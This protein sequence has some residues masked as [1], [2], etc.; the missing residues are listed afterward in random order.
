MNKN[1]TRKRPWDHVND[2][3]PDFQTSFGLLL[4]L[5]HLQVAIY[6]QFCVIAEH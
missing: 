3:Q 2:E 6:K 5:N 1:K 4:S